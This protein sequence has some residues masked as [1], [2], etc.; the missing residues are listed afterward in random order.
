MLES[1]TVQALVAKRDHL[2]EEVEALKAS[3]G[4]GE[5]EELN[6]AVGETKSGERTV[7]VVT[8]V[9]CDESKGK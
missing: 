2:R 4:A 5:E 7:L 1:S 6:E 9:E 3:L 8:G